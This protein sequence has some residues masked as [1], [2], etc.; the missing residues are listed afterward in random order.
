MKVL[1]TGGAGYLGSHVCVALAE[2][3]YQPV[4]ADNFSAASTQVVSRLGMIMKRPPVLEH[5]DVFSTGWMLEV[6]RR[7]EPCCV[8]HLAHY[9]SRLVTVADRLHYLGNNLTMLAS[10]LRAMEMHGLHTLQVAS[11]A[12]V[13]EPASTDRRTEHSARLP[14]S[15]MGQVHLMIENLLEGVRDLNPAW[16]MAVLRHFQPSGAHASGLIGPLPMRYNPGL[17]DSM[18]RASMG[19]LAQLDVYCQHPNTPDGT[20]VRDYTHVMD[21]ARAHAA[22][23]DALLDYD[24]GFTVN[25]G[26]GQAASVLQVVSTFEKVNRQLVPWHPLK[27]PLVEPAYQVADTSLA[28]HLI[29]WKA[30][31]SLEDICTDTLRWHSNNPHGYETITG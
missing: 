9:A 4:I 2:A 14:L 12:E 6:L 24:E 25:V 16:R 23:L 3:G 26:T 1:V 19:A 29:G 15:S 10:V 17:L 22:A 27:R 28:Q 5:G 21:T 31:H 8:V 18:A 30:R 7:H 20:A 13:Y 11:S